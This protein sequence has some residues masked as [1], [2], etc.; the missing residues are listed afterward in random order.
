MFRVAC[1]LVA[2]TPAATVHSATFKYDILRQGL[3]LVPNQAE[4][5]YFQENKKRRRV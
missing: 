2:A 4:E 3:V 5:V 1:M